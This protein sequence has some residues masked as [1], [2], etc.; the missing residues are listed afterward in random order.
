MKLRHAWL[1]SASLTMP[2]PSVAQTAS[3][4]E[5][6][7]IVV[8]GERVTRPAASTA[9][10]VS[11]LSRERIE[12]LPGA[13]RLEQ[14]LA[15]TP[16]LQ[17]GSGSEGPTIRGQDGNGPLRDMPAFLGGNRPRVTLQV[18]GRP[19]SYN[20]LAYGVAG[21]WDVERVEVFR[22]PQ[23]TTQGRNAIAGAIFVETASPSF[24]WEGRGR[25]LAGAAR[26]RQ[27]SAVISG[28]LITNEVAFRAT[29]DVRRSHTA[30]RITATVPGANY[31]A[32]DYDLLRFKL[33]AKPASIPGLSVTAVFSHSRSSAPQ[34]EGI[35]EPYRER[36]DP[37]ATYGL[38]KVRVDAATL[39]A[40]YAFAPGWSVNAVAT[41]GNA[42][43]RRLAPTG[44]GETRIQA[45]DHTV[46]AVVS[47]RPAQHLTV[48]AG[49]NLTHF[50]LKQRIDVRAALLGLGE[51]KD[52]QNALGAFAQAEWQPL[53][54]LTLTAGARY[55][56][57]EQD[58]VGVIGIGNPAPLPLDYHQSFARWLP[59]FSANLEVAPD[60]NVGALV[61]RAYNAGGVTLDVKRRVADRF[62]AETLWAKEVFIRF[63]PA[64]ARLSV[65][66]NAFH[67][68]IK[69]AQRS[70]ISELA[71]P[72][73]VVT[74]SEIGNVP[75]ARSEGAEVEGR[76]QPT[77]MLELRGAIGLLRT[78]LTR[79]LTPTDPL[80]GKEFQRSPH[81]TGSLNA[82]WHPQRQ[83]WFTLQARHNSSYY[84]EDTNDPA[85]RVGSATVVDLGAEWKHDRLT[86][87]GYARN[88]FDRFYLTYLVPT[89]FRRATAGDPREVGVAAALRF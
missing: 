25:L 4:H 35:R 14:V 71:T 70:V 5:G 67:Y 6:E 21:L 44:F 86:L 33:L 29:A 80:V 9:S 82:S 18:D 73:G 46:E 81:L 64:G 1:V 37:D 63:N 17:F 23:T 24:A 72:G 77:D 60:L 76:W 13:D 45:N 11:V 65:A 40:G 28:P 47:G 89:A 50:S 88:V 42:T 78:R 34:I 83:V 27:A 85:G 8:T 52:R 69:N 61:Q 36:R 41:R 54:R 38:F 68:S 3:Q 22:S 20:E 51:F 66:A 19:V 15:L 59:K 10:S 43:I 12:A 49:A 26:T 31:N 62:D 84:S 79:A 39:R 16:N 75:S 87:S 32:D 48:L 74:V 7:A 56:R 30:S 57:D 53:P 2:A 55:Q 58:R